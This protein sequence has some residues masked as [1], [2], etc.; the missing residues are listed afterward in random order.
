MPIPPA[1]NCAFARSTSSRRPPCRTFCA[2]TC[3]NIRIFTNLPDKVSIQLNDTHPAISIAE[4]MRLLCDVHGLDFE[5]AWTITRGTFSY[6]NHTL[7]PEALESWPVPLLERLLPRHMQIIYA[8][9]A[10]TLI[11][12]RKEKKLSDGQ[13]RSISLIDEGGERR[14]RMGN[15]AFI[16]SHSIMASRHSIPN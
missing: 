8:I 1:R 13:I 11:F 3:S 9:N 7:L 14:V 4:M 6:T 10:N 15:L 2:V 16:G 5:E 12:A